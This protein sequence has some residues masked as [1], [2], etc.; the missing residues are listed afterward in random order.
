MSLG[1]SIP[2]FLHHN[3]PWIKGHDQGVGVWVKEPFSTRDWA[4]TTLQLSL[5]NEMRNNRLQVSA[6]H[7]SCT[8][9][10]LLYRNLGVRSRDCAQWTIKMVT[11]LAFLPG[12]LRP[13]SNYRKNWKIA[14]HGAHRHVRTVPTYQEGSLLLWRRTWSSCMQTSNAWLSATAYGEDYIEWP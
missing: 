2:Y 11:S 10:L 7:V 3:S 6:A 14:W 5:E 12:S 1:H 8:E 13:N 9:L 4:E